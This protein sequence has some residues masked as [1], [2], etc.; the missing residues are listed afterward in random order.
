[1]R[2]MRAYVRDSGRPKSLFDSLNNKWYYNDYNY[3]NNNN[4][5]NNDDVNNNDNDNTS[6]NNDN[7]ENNSKYE[8]MIT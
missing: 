7:D 6:S 1:M 4:N 5:N 2:S 3:N 8:M